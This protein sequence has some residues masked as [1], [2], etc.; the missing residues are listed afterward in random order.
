MKLASAT[1]RSFGILFLS[2]FLIV[3]GAGASSLYSA[4]FMA[5]LE[6]AILAA[7]ASETVVTIETDVYTG[8]AKLDILRATDGSLTGLSYAGPDGTTT[9]FQLD[10]LRNNFK[11]LKNLDG[12]DAV[13]LKV[14]PAFSAQKGGHAILRVLR[15][16][17]S[18]E[19][20]NFRVLVKVGAKI[21]AKIEMV[22]DPDLNDPDSDKNAYSGPFNY[23]FMK[24]N[25]VFGM[26]IGIDEIVPQLR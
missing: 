25:T 4:D 23:V 3:S 15:N 8:T 11:V 26:T 16:G 10:D 19:F 13:L 17:I 2:A 1:F 20:K 5:E 18:N 7:F 6:Q 9:A 22:S 14:D 24:K 21:E 12:H